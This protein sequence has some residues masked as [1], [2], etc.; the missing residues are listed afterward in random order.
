MQS[1]P[2]STARYLIVTSLKYATSVATSVSFVT[3]CFTFYAIFSEVR[4]SPLLTTSGNACCCV[5]WIRTEGLPN[6]LLNTDWLCE[7]P[8]TMGTQWRALSWSELPW[9]GAPQ[10]FRPFS[11]DRGFV[12]VWAPSEGSR[13]GACGVYMSGGGADLSV[14]LSWAWGEGSCPRHH[15]N[16]PPVMTSLN[17]D[18]MMGQR[19]GPFKQGLITLKF[20]ITGHPAKHS[21]S[22]HSLVFCWSCHLRQLT[23]CVMYLQLTVKCTNNNLNR[24][25]ELEE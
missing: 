9:P 19:G 25:G 6:G 18:L 3:H 23:F 16:E 7:A 21:W 14:A 10:P 12:F 24:K 11:S 4:N 20:T 8:V 5:A 17:I 22:G 13:G 2:D 1:Y 15:S